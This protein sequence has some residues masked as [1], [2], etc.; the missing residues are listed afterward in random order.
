MPHRLATTLW[1]ASIFASV[2]TI[3]GRLPLVAAVEDKYLE[4]IKVS[5]NVY[6]FKPKIDW[7][8]GNG[9]AIIGPDGVFFIDTYIQF[10]YADEAIRRLRRVTKLPVR[11]VLNTHWHNDHVTGNGV[12]KREFPSAQ[13]IAHDSTPGYL[14]KIVKPSVD[15]EFILIKSAIAQLDSEVST[16]A[17]GRRRVPIVGTMKPFWEQMLRNARD[18]EKEFRPARFANADITFSDSLTIRWGAQTL[19]LIHMAEN[20]HSAGDV[21]VW[22]PEQRILVT[23][24][25]VVGP[26]PY[27]TYYN[28]PG[29]IKALH[30]LIAMNPAIVIPGHG[31]I[32]HDLRYMQL[33]ERAFT[34]YRQAAESAVAAKV[35]E[36]RA[37]DS[38]TLPEIDRAFVG[39]DPL[40][41]W[42]YRTF[43]VRNLIHNTY[44]PTP[45]P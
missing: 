4:T 34:E 1:V 29:M 37:V 35:P 3:P 23:G 11:Y 40:K 33:L 21:V 6:V 10:N 36:A 18:Y 16:G 8:H 17:T 41:T 22:I 42:A 44:K 13:I 12:F 5:E 45:G 39:D 32:Q 14:E 25:I 19:R 15:S 43:F 9:V 24:D 30:S 27:A 31:V 2:N 28:I 20:G 7:N 38:L 26:T